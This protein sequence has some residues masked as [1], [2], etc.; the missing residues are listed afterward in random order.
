MAIFSH[1]SRASKFT[2]TPI[3]QRLTFRAL[4]LRQSDWRSG[5][6]CGFIIRK[7]SYAIGGN[8]VTR[9]QE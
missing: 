6:L 8:M 7:R 2:A 3:M 1:H 4:A 5:G 9:K